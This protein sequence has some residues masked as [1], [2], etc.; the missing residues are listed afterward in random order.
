M[1]KVVEKKFFF[2]LNVFQKLLII[3]Q[4]LIIVCLFI[5]VNKCIDRNIL[6]LPTY[7]KH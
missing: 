1:H 6:H 4:V 2:S 7:F 3:T 5:S